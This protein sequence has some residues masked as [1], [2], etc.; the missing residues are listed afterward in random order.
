[1][2]SAGQMLEKKSKKLLKGEDI[3]WSEI[4]DITRK[5]QEGLGDDFVSLSR[6]KSGQVP[7]IPSGWEAFDKHFYGIPEVGMILVGGDPGIGKTTFMGQMASCFAK[8]H[9]E[10]IIAIFSLEMI[11]CELAARFREVDKLN[12]D[13]EERILLNENMLSADEI[14]NKASTIE[15]L[16]LVCVDFGDL[17]V[18]ENSEPAYS[19]MYKT[20]MAGAKQLHVPIIVL[21]QLLKNKSGVPTPSRL[22]YTRMAEAFAWMIL[23]LFDPSKDWD[24]EDGTS[25]ILPIKEGTAYIIGWK[26]RGG[27]RQ[28]KE[29]FPGAIMLP[30]S[31]DK[32]WGLDGKRSKW[33]SLRKV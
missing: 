7:F 28:H 31:G 17:V 33:Y 23:F 30:F 3:D 22:R 8:Q 26:I 12:S 20:L 29:D 10:K 14:I 6:V 27:A 1:M 5:A 25:S 15:N 4:T 32:G 24:S 2:Y 11:L 21:V 16:G 19:K 18:E 9:P 13:V